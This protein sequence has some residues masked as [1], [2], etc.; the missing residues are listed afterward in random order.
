MVRS[1]AYKALAY[2]YPE[3]TVLGVPHPS[4]A[5]GKHWDNLFEKDRLKTSVR[6]VCRSAIER[7]TANWIRRDR[8]H[9]L[10]LDMRTT[11][12]HEGS[13]ERHPKRLWVANSRF[14]G[15]FVGDDPDKTRHLGRAGRRD[16]LHPGRDGTLEE[17]T[18]VTPVPPF[19]RKKE[20]RN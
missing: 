12:H 6:N 7:G 9:S 8:S 13:A 16:R 1:E 19:P 15:D 20:G 10:S 3:R 18:P 17:V 11:L 4:G 5:R 2:L 14:V